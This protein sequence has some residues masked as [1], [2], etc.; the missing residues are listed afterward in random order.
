MEAAAR[1]WT[2]LPVDVLVQILDHLRWSSHPSFGLVCRQWQSARAFS[3]FYPAWI[4]PLLLNATDLG[5]TNLRY[6]SP[7][8][9]KNFETSSTLR[10]PDVKIVC[11]TGQHLTLC[12]EHLI[13]EAKLLSSDDVHQLPRTKNYMFDS[14]VYDGVHRMFGVDTQFG[15]LGIA[16]CIRD[17]T[18]DAWGDWDYASYDYDQP[19]FLTSQ[20]CN[21]VLRDGFLYLLG[22]DGALAVYDDTRHDQG[23]SILDK[24][25]SFIFD[26][27]HSYLVKSDQ[28][29]LM[30]I[31]IGHR[32]TPV[33]VVKLNEH[34]MQWEK[35][36]NLEGR[37][38]F[39]GTLTTTV[40]K[41][42]IKWMHNKIFLPR[43][44]DWPEN[45]HV[46]LVQREDDVAFVPKNGHTNTAV[47]HDD[48]GTKVWSYELGQPQEA[49][50][51]WG[52]ERV[53]YGIWINFST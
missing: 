46:D 39:T 6:Y 1:D 27:K 5:T 40:K 15:M 31:L 23:F 17:N 11:A 7:Y 9:H 29:E 26:Y 35:M 30:A 51:F 19:T 32:G 50:E 34:T 21:P 3:P 25:Q 4:T 44:Y 48:F 12:S 8:Y 14:V 18:I 41:T 45:V 47:K 13:I 42:N 28:G 43:L 53:D 10:T 52:T 38:L 49:I 24:P 36:E 20:D 33:N 22:E 37:A 16:R 2:S